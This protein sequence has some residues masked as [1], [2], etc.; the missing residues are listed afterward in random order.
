MHSIMCPSTCSKPF[1]HAV[2]IVGHGQILIAIQSEVTI[3]SNFDNN[4]VKIHPRSDRT[5]VQISIRIQLDCDRDCRRDRNSIII[6]L[7]FDFDWVQEASI[8]SASS[9]TVG[10]QPRFGQ[11]TIGI[12]PIVV[13]SIVAV[14]DRDLVGFRLQFDYSRNSIEFQQQSDRN[15]ITVQSAHNRIAIEI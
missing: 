1:E 3:W 14:G 12:Q 10:F 2:S 13:A 6:R 7:K 5:Y 8:G 9:M 15:S 4:L 11:I